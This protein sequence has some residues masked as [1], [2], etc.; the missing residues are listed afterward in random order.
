MNV[1]VDDLS[2][3]LIDSS[4][5]P[6]IYALKGMG[7]CFPQICCLPFLFESPCEIVS[8]SLIIDYY[9]RNDLKHFQPLHEIMEVLSLSSNLREVESMME[10]RYKD[11]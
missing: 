11:Y 10:C 8:F 9:Y 7:G 4:D 6:P 5:M 3:Y 2:V 1:D